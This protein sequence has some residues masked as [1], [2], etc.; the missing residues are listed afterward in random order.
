MER[1]HGGPVSTLGATAL[2]AGC[3]ALTL[4]AAG[5]AQGQ[6][7]PG[8]ALT[9]LE[10]LG[11]RI[12]NDRNLSEPRGTA[13]IDCHVPAQGF[14]GNNG[15]RIG[16]AQGSKPGSIGGRNAMSNA[17]TAFIPGFSFRVKDGDVD[18]LGGLFWDGRANTAAQQALGPLLNPL[19]MNNPDIASVVRKIASAPYAQQFRDEFGPDILRTPEA[20]FT[21]VGLAVAAYERTMELQPFNSRY[22]QFIQSKGSLSPQE[23]NGMKVFMDPNKGNCASCHLMNP[24]SSNPRDSLFSDWAHYNL[25]IPRNRQI[26]RNSNP[27]FFDLGLCG[28][29]RTRPALSA[30][31]PADVTIERFCG[32]FRMVSLRNVAD[33]TAWMHNGFFKSLRDVVSFYATRNTDPKRWYGP[34][35]VPNDVPYAYRANVISDRVPFN[36]PANA[37]PAL[38]ER[39][40]DDV[41]AFLRTLSD[42]PLSGRAGPAP[43]GSAS[44]NPFGR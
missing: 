41:V 21:K 14:A 6:P 30:D 22:D 26:P 17:Y 24:S 32:A 2:R 43:S 33:R 1:V 31:V 3:L 37:G 4:A 11:Q 28:P 42:A 12:F 7:R 38:S 34:A 25:G 39:E 29:D 10:D 5:L 18:P 35:G 20:A 40:I 8:G 23:L 9:R 16:V 15:L 36:R 19:E 27:S 13:C 44:I